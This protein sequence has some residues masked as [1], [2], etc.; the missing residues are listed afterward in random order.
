MATIGQNALSSGLQCRAI[1]DASHMVPGSSGEPRLNI[2]FI[3][4]VSSRDCLIDASIPARAASLS[5]SEKPCM[6]LTSPMAAA[7]RVVPMP[8]IV[9]IT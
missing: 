1:T 5:V 8:R 6:S 9:S 3:E 2:R 4:A 7:A